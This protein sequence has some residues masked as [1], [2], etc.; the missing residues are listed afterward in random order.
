M[1]LVTG[2]TGKVGSEAVL[3]LRRRQVPVRALVRDRPK[4]QSL[5]DA[6]AEIAVGDFDAPASLTLA[7]DGVDTVLLI[8]PGA[9]PAQ[10]LAV[11]DAAALAGV[12]HVVKLTSKAAPDSPIA[13]SRGHA[14]VEQALAASGLRYTLLRSNAYMQNT[15]MLASTIAATSSFSSSAGLGRIGMTDARDVAA[16]AAQVA[17]DPAEHEGKTYW[18]SGPA[19]L[20]YADVATVLT[21]VLG[22][23]ITYQPRSR[24]DEETEMIRAGLPQ[25]VAQMNAHALSMFA[26][27]DAEWL[28]PDVTA[29]LDRPARSFEQFAT[30][31]AAA[32][33]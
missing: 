8:S 16:V 7:V 1:I 14:K 12:R 13:R 11:I 10:E 2:A 18:L 21:R 31:F 30:D 9:D 29:L 26:D 28:S 24:A 19:L 33:S 25:P 32:F 6:G 27:G 20:T 22:R 3:G 15:L 23:A 4:A 5:A 17:A